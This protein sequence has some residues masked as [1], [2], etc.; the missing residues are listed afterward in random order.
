M[1]AIVA[2]DVVGYA[3]HM[4]DDEAGTVA[5][6][7][8]LRHGVIDV[9]AVARGGRVTSAAGDG[10]ILAFASAAEAVA[11]AVDLQ[12]RL[13][14]QAEDARPLL[15]RAGVNTGDVIVRGGDVSGDAVNVAARLEAAAEPGGVLVSEA[16]LSLARGRVPATFA[17]VGRLSLKNIS[18]PVEAW[19]WH[20]RGHPYIRRALGG[21]AGRLLWPVPRRGNLLAAEVTHADFEGPPAADGGR[22]FLVA[23]PFSNQGEDDWFADGVT[24]DLITGM[25]R[26]LPRA[27]SVVAR[28]TSFALKGRVGDPREAGRELGVRYTLDGRVRRRG[29]R[30]RIVAELVDTAT[31]AIAWTQTFD[32]DRADLALGRDEI[33]ARIGNALRYEVVTA[34]G[35][36]ARRKAPREI[37]AD[38]LA[39]QGWATFYRPRSVGQLRA[40]CELFEQA[41]AAG[42]C[43]GDV[44]VGLAL[45]HTYLA[46]GMDTCPDQHLEE[47]GRALERARSAPPPGAAVPYAEGL[48]LRARGSGRRPA[49]RSSGRSASTRT[50]PTLASSSA[51]PTAAPASRSGCS[52]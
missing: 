37:V 18:R 5:R 10:F 9:L 8:H 4:E 41:S 44:G 13:A 50:I 52:R 15:M 38:D 20:P 49:A 24:E 25:A 7:E 31:G 43:S 11:F 12:T 23:L 32:G 40:A 17:P 33:V 16:A 21:E 22:P 29:E 47:A 34:A 35:E 30:V 27:G 1:R 46:L 14:E 39:M 45:T 19:H 36:R 3:R 28:G 42:P 51:S 48:L 26:S 6:L 2:A